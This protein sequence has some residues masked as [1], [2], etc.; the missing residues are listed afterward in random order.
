MQKDSSFRNLLITFFLP[1]LLPGFL[2][3]ACTFPEFNPVYGPGVDPPLSWVFNF[4]FLSGNTAGK[5]F[6]FPHGPLSFLLYPLPMGH[7]VLLGQLIYTLL[8]LIFFFQV[9]WLFRIYRPGEW[10]LSFLLIYLVFLLFEIQFVMLGII[11]S[12]FALYLSTDN[13]RYLWLPILVAS[14]GMY[15]RA[16]ITVTGSLAVLASLAILWYRSGNFRRPLYYLLLWITAISLLWLSLYH[17]LSG[18]IQYITGRVYLTIDNSTAASYYPDNNWTVL[19]LSIACLLAIPLMQRSKNI[20]LYFLFFLPILFAQWKYSM[21]RQDLIHSRGYFVMLVLL[22]ILLVPQVRSKK[23]MTLLLAL[24]SL[25]FYYLN[26][27]R[28]AGYSEYKVNLVKLNSFVDFVTNYPT[29]EKSWIRQSEENIR[30]S[31]MEES[32]KEIIGQQT[33]DCYPWDYTYIAANNL[34][35]QPRPVIQSYASYTAWLDKKNA[36]HFSSAMAP[37]FVLWHLAVD[38]SDPNGGQFES[39]DFR[40]LL[41]DEPQTLVTLLSHYTLRAK[42]DKLLLYEKREKPLPIQSVMLSETKTGWNTWIQVPVVK[43]GLL[44]V[45]AAIQ[46]NLKGA[47][48]SF[49]YKNEA[50]FILLKTADEQIYRYRIVAKN[51]AEGIWITPLILHP[52]NN[53]AEPVITQILFTSTDPQMQE[54]SISL[55][56]EIIQPGNHTTLSDTAQWE[57]DVIQQW[58]GKKNSSEDSVRLFSK[59]TTLEAAQHWDIREKRFYTTDF[60]SPPM[61]WQ[62]DS[63]SYSYSFNYDYDSSLVTGNEPKEIRVGAGVWVKSSGHDQADL[64]ISFDINGVTRFYKSSAIKDYITDKNSWNYVLNNAVIPAEW[65]QQGKGHL[66]VYVWNPGEEKLLLDDFQVMLK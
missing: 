18:L 59:N 54:E 5:E 53:S 4:I 66:K 55:Q 26:L 65:M 63:N 30:P 37:H 3:I 58:F 56:W 24:G 51:A 42:T 49:L 50:S 32:L 60:V 21:A 1:G 7:Q 29:L 2:L 12:G 22:F 38:G 40:Y 27:P 19:F 25:C 6:V 34:N 46:N 31:K 36:D 52:E 10:L 23:F 16:Y 47:L 11:V 8:K 44:R 13:H 41:N 48:K 20:C 9:T 64:V 43:G 17:S 35:W 28:V 61:S 15:M 62:L 39:L 45:K 57:H 14:L 33:V